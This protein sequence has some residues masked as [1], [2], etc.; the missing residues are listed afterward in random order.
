MGKG[1]R[2]GGE[3]PWE[4]VLEEVRRAL[5][6]AKI[7]DDGVQDALIEGLRH[8]LGELDELDEL[9]GGDADDD[10][11]DD[12]V[13]RLPGRPD[14]TV[15]E[16]GRA[17]DDAPQAPGPRPD[18]RVAAPLG[19]VE[20]RSRRDEGDDEDHEDDDDGPEG[21]FDGPRVVAHIRVLRRG[22][23]P[24]ADLDDLDAGAPRSLEG[25]LRVA[26]GEGQPVFR[27]A[28]PHCY[29]IHCDLGAIDV[30]AD[31]LYIQRVR[32]GQ[33]IDVEGRDV[34]VE[35]A[36]PDESAG[37]YHRIGESG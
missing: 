8:A 1:G 33:S 2:R 12:G 11:D 10:A 3:P 13:T 4:G 23:D 28:S 29:R 36:G 24:L 19:T 20:G 14:V 37:R 7:E 16:G 17:E 31:E 30:I 32:V 21:G 35:G 27:G 15:V 34:R 25:Q 9:G 18:L 22:A 6:E 26:P 5:V